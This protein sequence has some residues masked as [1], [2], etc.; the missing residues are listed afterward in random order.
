MEVDRE[1]SRQVRRQRG[2]ASGYTIRRESTFEDKVA[3]GN[4]ARRDA[5]VRPCS[6]GDAYSMVVGIGFLLAE[7]LYHSTF[8][9]LY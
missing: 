6:E 1:Q 2:A 7:N 4:S 8:H 5:K 3:A 9:P